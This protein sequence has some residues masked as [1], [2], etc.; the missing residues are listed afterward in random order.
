MFTGHPEGV[1]GC[2]LDVVFTG[3][4]EGVQGCLLDVVFTGQPGVD[5]LG[6]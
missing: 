3:H 6:G 2:L 5:V 4:P 1:Q